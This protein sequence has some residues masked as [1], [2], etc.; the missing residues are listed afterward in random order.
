MD[1]H[2]RSPLHQMKLEHGV[3]SDP[4]FIEEE[5]H[6]KDSGENDGGDD[7]TTRPRFGHTAPLHEEDDATTPAHDDCRTQPVT[8]GHL[9]DHGSVVAFVSGCSTQR[10]GGGLEDQDARHRDTTKG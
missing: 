4:P 7:R 2:D 5:D 6:R 3:L 8:L 10:R 1:S 9:P